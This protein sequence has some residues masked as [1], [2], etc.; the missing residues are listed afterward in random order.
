MAKENYNRALV[1]DSNYMA[2]SIISSARAFVICY[3]GNAEV[4][5]EHPESFNLGDTD[6]EIMKP[7]II[8][9]FNTMP[10]MFNKVALTRENIYKRDNYT[11]VYCGN[12]NKKELTLDHVYPKSKGG[13]NSWSNLVTACKTCNNEKADM[14]VDEY[15]N[16]VPI[17]KRP[18]YLMLMKQLEYLPEEWKSF[19]LM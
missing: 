15:T 4:I 17:A 7:S 8:R 13:P 5:A 2:R 12:E 6:V 14:L 3:K 19:L 10:M 16:D 11:C 18:H 9:V 1:I